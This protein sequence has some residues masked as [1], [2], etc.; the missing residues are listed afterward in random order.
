MSTEP[1]VQQL[2]DVK[3]KHNL[4]D[5][6]LGEGL[7]VSRTTIHRW[8]KGESKPS[9]CLLELALVSPPFLKFLDALN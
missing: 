9:G 7:E 5:T 6:K 4:S 2:L 8:K 3:A 1:W